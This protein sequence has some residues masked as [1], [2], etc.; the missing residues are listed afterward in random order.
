M[1]TKSDLNESECIK[2]DRNYPKNSDR[3]VWTNIE[4][5]DQTPQTKQ[6][7]PD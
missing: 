2:I 4:D 6:C 3:Q 5:S 1:C 7:D